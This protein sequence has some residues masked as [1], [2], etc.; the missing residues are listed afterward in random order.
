M[1]QTRPIAPMT[2]LGKHQRL[3]S[4]ENSNSWL[5]RHDDEG[6]L[7]IQ[8]GYRSNPTAQAMSNDENPIVIMNGQTRWYGAIA[9]EGSH[10]RSF[11]LSKLETA[12]SHFAAC[13]RPSDDGRDLIVIAAHW[14]SSEFKA[15][16]AALTG[17][18]DVIRNGQSICCNV[19]E[20]KP[21]LEGL[22]SYNL[23]NA[24]LKP[25]S[26]LVVEM[27][28]GT[29]ET[30]VINNDGQV[31]DGSPVTQLG[32]LKLVNAIAADPTVRGV[33]SANNSTSI[34][35]S[36]I[37]RALKQDTLGRID[38]A[39]WGAIKTRYATEFLKSF[40][41]YLVSQFESQQQNVVNMI[42]T[43]GGAELLQAIQPKLSSMFII[44]TNAQTASVRGSYQLGA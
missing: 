41:G 33:L 16:Q 29:A 44:P 2:Q 8:A 3:V 20:V 19:I 37:S 35:L 39:T 15:L 32:I 5:K 40:Q 17:Q 9:C 10:T 31:I 13:L 21:V 11:E 30:W 25:G 14:D 7:V 1:V 24:Q 28:F 38:A 42:L 18:Y 43:G 26:T 12:R 4:F 6:T 27:G 36:L 22:G 23:V 34:N